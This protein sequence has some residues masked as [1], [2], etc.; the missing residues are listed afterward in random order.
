MGSKLISIMDVKVKCPECGL[1]VR[2]GDAE[3]D[4]DGD[5]SLGCPRCLSMLSTSSADWLNK[6]TINKATCIGCGKPCEE[7]LC[8]RCESKLNVLEKALADIGQKLELREVTV[9]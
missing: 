4:I 8:S 7:G 3:P 9:L 5:G 2:V 1:V 6:R